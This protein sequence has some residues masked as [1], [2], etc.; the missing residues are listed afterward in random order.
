MSMVIAAEQVTGINCF[1]AICS[2]VLAPRTKSPAAS[3]PYGSSR[4]SPGKR[5]SSQVRAKSSLGLSIAANWVTRAAAARDCPVCVIVISIAATICC[6]RGSAEVCVRFFSQVL[7]AFLA[8]PSFDLNLSLE[9]TKGCKQILEL[10]R[11]DV[12]RQLPH[13]HFR[14][15]QRDNV[16]SLGL[17]LTPQGSKR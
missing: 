14:Y 17:V 7:T 1:C 15:T 2:S 11:A 10:L 13:I 5:T 4:I 3:G 9:Q 6:V 8:L 16:Q 12:L